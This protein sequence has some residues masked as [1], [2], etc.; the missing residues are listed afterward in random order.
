M[1]EEEFSD[2][3][4]LEELFSNEKHTEIKR[5][6][7]YLKILN[8][9]HK[10]IM[11]STKSK[12]GSKWVFFVIPEVVIGIPIYNLNLCRAYLIKKLNENGFE[13]KYTHP[14]LLFISWNHIVPDYVRKEIKQNTGYNVDKFGNIINKKS[15]LELKNEPGPIKKKADPKNDIKSSEDYV[16]SGIYNT[17]FLKSLDIK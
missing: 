8:R 1:Y 16:N 10:K 12:E 15:I 4:D 7:I 11:T 9:V 3:I 5:K 17:D 6:D 14:N 13:V 2:K